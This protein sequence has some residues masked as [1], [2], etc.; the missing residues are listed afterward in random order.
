MVPTGSF[1]LED[2]DAAGNGKRTPAGEHKSRNDPS[3]YVSY[4]EQVFGGGNLGDDMKHDQ[5]EKALDVMQDMCKLGRL[6]FLIGCKPKRWAENI[7]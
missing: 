1:D 5:V 6:K 7:A 2:T 4:G 3:I